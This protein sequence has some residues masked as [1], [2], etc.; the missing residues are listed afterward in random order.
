MDSWTRISTSSGSR[1]A[2]KTVF[3]RSR[4][5]AIGQQHVARDSIASAGKC[6]ALLGS[7]W[8]VRIIRVRMYVWERETHHTTD[9]AK[10]L[11]L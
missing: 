6:V 5:H 4:V 7:V 1:A 11:N 2:F 10:R 9:C 3:P 8:W